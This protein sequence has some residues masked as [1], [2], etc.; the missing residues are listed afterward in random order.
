MYINA[1]K[2]P[3]SHRELVGEM[4]KDMLEQGVIQE[5]SSPSNSPIFLVPKKDGTFRPVIDF[6]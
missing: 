3:Y 6:Q 5:S 1:Y 4:I 2:L